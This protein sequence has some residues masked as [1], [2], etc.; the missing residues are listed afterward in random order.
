MMYGFI[1][2]MRKVLPFS[3]LLSWGYSYHVKLHSIKEQLRTVRK[4]PYVFSQK[5]EHN[6]SD[7]HLW[8]EDKVRRYELWL[9]SSLSWEKLCKWEV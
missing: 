2:Y 6:D 5:M 8:H 7:R 1:V 3:S 4:A 9:E